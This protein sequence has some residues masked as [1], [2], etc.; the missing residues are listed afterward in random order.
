M[1]AKL[2]SHCSLRRLCWLSVSMSI[3]AGCDLATDPLNDLVVTNEKESG[4]PE[5]AA[6]L[7]PVDPNG[8][9]LIELTKCEAKMETISRYK[10]SV[11]YRFASGSPKPNLEYMI[12]VSFPGCPFRDNKRVSGKDLKADGTIEWQYE[13]PG[14]GARGDSEVTDVRFQFHEEFERQGNRREYLGVSKP[15]TTKLDTSILGS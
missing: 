2:F 11:T 5:P 8:K 6:P 9:T 4:V 1:I 14:I 10:L 7:P 13:L 12:D 15:F 3:L